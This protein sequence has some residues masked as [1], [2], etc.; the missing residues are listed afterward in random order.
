MLDYLAQTGILGGDPE[1]LPT[2]YSIREIPGRCANLALETD[3]GRGVFVKQGIGPA[4]RETVRCEG[5]ALKHLGS[6]PETATLVAELIAVD[7]ARGLVVT[8]VVDGA[9][10][11]ATVPQA[12]R[13]QCAVPLAHALG[14]LHAVG[15][16]PSIRPTP[17][18]WVL[19]VHRP[20]VAGL[21]EIDQ[22]MWRALG[23]VQ[24]RTAVVAAL[25]TLAA[26]WSTDSVIHY[27]V[28][29][30]NTLV[31]DAWGGGDDL[32]LIDFE[33]CGLGNP[34]WD[35]GCLLAACAWDELDAAHWLS[36]ETPLD[37]VLQNGSATVY[38]AVVRAYRTATGLDADVTRHRVVTAILMA[39]AR[40]VQYVT[41]TDDPGRQARGLLIAERLLCTTPPL[42]G[43]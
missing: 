7:Q 9:A 41:E 35:L 34:A 25:D 10:V 33:L 23:M 42:T 29:W 32:R 20:V 15:A 8:R 4:G 14:R 17:P 13:V 37:T 38:G 30:A 36:S 6:V 18:P 40:L 12:R 22:A 39:G 3:R 43:P 27:D 2:R 1:R 19:C 24:A 16:W 21:S 31:R 28:T 11:L 5:D 26:Q